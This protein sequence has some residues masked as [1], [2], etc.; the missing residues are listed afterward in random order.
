M[1]YTHIPSARVLMLTCMAAPLLFAHEPGAAAAPPDAQRGVAHPEL[2]PSTHSVGLVDART[3]ARV[4][5]L[6]ARMSLEEK[7]GQLIQ[8][9]IGHIKP[10]DL[11]RFPVGSI[12]AGGSTPPLGAGD[13]APTQAWIDTARAFR[14][15]SIE[16]RAGHVPV[17]VIF[18][19][20]AVH[21]NNNIVGATLFPHNIALGATH[22]PA[23]LRRIGAATA[24]EVAASGIDWAFGP[25]LAVP[26]DARWGRAYEGYS[27]DPALVRAYA[28]EMVLGLQGD[29]SKGGL[30]Q[31]GHVAAS[32]K[33]FLA[34]GGT[35]DG[36]DQ[37]DADI[38]EATLIHT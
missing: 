16:A 27:Q 4:T 34:D 33:H 38:D 6:L 23:L 20:D 11:R 28:S 21:G 15:V 31:Q 2:W 30:L 17:P 10:E 18:G 7:V 25:T 29:V 32:A 3:E 22:D 37:G 19:I 13:R 35:R 26:Q 24:V 1:R 12:L 5:G 36:I 9:D 14:A 8:A